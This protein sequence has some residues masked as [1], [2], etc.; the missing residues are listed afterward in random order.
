MAEYE[1]PVHVQG[2]EPTL[3]TKTYHTISEAL[4]YDNPST[5]RTYHIVIQQDVEIPDV[6]HHMLCPMQVRTN[7]KDFEKEAYTRRTSLCFYKCLRDLD[8]Q[9]VALRDFASKV[10]FR[11]R[12]LSAQRCFR[13]DSWIF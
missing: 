12:T 6:K 5:G 11:T 13:V 2:C 4:L 1:S 10:S 9:C 7:T 8:I 3:G